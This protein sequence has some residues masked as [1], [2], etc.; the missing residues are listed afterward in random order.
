[1]RSIRRTV[2]VLLTA[3]GLSLGSVAVTVPASGTTSYPTLT[4]VRY[5][6]QTGFDRVVF[7]FSG[8]LPSWTAKF[9]TLEGEGTGDPIP[10]AGA[11][12]LIVRF[13]PAR[14]HDDSGHAT[15]PIQNTLDPNLPAV[16]QIRFGGDYEGYV[17]VGLGLRDIVAYKI[18]T[19]TDRVVI[20]I[21]HPK[22]FRTSDV[23]ASGTLSNIRVD[24]IRAARQAAGY[25]RVVWD[26]RG[27]AKPSYVV[28]YSGDTSLLLVK[29]T[30]PGTA[31]FYGTTP[32]NPGLPGV[33]RITLGSKSGGTMIFRMSTAAR[34]GFRVSFL[35]SPSRLVVDVKH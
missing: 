33:K 35:T 19:L 12:D 5:A 13:N 14:A 28:R 11:V 23:S 34:H 4:N 6:K 29:L 25:D 10:V 3:L 18:Y 22:P 15:Y 8:E 20:D 31:S 21:T 30:G 24:R 27:T 32:M 17:S 2:V 26:I 7:D 1:M 16:R 9:G